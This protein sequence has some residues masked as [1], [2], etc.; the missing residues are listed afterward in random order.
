MKLFYRSICFYRWLDEDEDDGKIVREL[1]VQEEYAT[2]L[3]EK[4]LVNYRI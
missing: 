3:I 2:D 4:T 1:R